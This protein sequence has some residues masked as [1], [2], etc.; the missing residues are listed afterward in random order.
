[1]NICRLKKT[2]RELRIAILKKHEVGYD[3]WIS[4][5]DPG[6]ALLSRG[7]Q[8]FV[9]SQDEEEEDEGDSHSE[10]EVQGGF[11]VRCVC[12]HVCVRVCVHVCVCVC[13]C[14]CAVVILNV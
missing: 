4:H 6:G 9:D 7:C 12:V 14:M 13:V 8:G 1:V 3:K 2:E 5:G 11:R 10:G